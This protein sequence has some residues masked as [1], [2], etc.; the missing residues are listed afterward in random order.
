[1]SVSAAH[2]L[3]DVSTK[4]GC[5]VLDNPTST[6]GLMCV[7]P[8]RFYIPGLLRYSE[9]KLFVLSEESGLAG[10]HTPLIE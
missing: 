6:I 4:F 1:M 2:F 9:G 10:T 7:I 8:A 3:G 5:K